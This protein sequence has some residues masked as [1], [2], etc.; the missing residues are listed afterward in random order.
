MPM[1]L[2]RAIALDPTSAQA[3]HLRRVGGTARYAH[4]WG[5]AE[6]RRMCKSG[7]KPSADKIK[8]CWNAYRKGELPWPYDVTEYAGGQAILDL[9]SAFA[10]FFRDCKKPGK[11]RRC[12][13]RTQR[14]HLCTFRKQKYG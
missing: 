4:N 12:L 14:A 7:E 1:I 3:S 10:K 13:T 11:Q 6:W 5:L 2:G 9:G 8:R